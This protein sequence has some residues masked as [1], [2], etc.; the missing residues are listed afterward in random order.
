[1]CV[2]SNLGAK[3]IEVTVRLIERVSVSERGD[4]GEL[5]LAPTAKGL[6]IVGTEKLS[7]RDGEISLCRPLPQFLT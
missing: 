5:L 2:T 1:M 4:R 3:G 7:N 6:S